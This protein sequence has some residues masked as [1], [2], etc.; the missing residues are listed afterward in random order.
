MPLYI[1]IAL[2][3]LL[4]LKS[5][6]LSFMT[7][8]SFIGITVGVSAL[9][10]T[11]AVM[12]GFQWGLK[13]KILETSPHIVIFKMTGRF[14]EYSSLY[15]YFTDIKDIEAYQPFIYSQALASKGENVKSV[16]IRGVDPDKDKKIMKVNTKLIAGNYDDLKKRNHVLIGKDVAVA[17]DI[18]V[19]D[20]FKIMSPFGRKTPLGYLPKIKKV[21]VAGI[22]DFGMYEYDSTYI[23]MR[24]DEAQNFFDMKDAVTGIQIKLRNPY[25][26][27]TV[28]KQLE[29]YIS[30][31]YIIR[32][33]MDLN[34][35]L[36]QAL[37]LEKLAMFLV[38][39]LI[40]LVASF[41][42]SSLLITKAREKRKDIAIL[43]TI[44]ADS[45]FILK[46]FL[47]QGMLIGIA[48]TVF[49]TII[50][51]SVIYFGDT[52][53]LVKLNPEVYM[54]DYL[55]L[56]TSIFDITAVFLSSLFIC[57]VSSVLPAYFASRDVP[58]E[59]LRYE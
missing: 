45:S 7:V 23:Q 38:I 3:Y 6:A 52:Y 31:P 1:K 57:F 43:K 5:K 54:I 37:Q 19:G 15:D 32:T 44:G 58:A 35:S 12:S 11:L 30:Y 2:K 8:I 20:S 4:S 24:L 55:P 27:D 34:K 18:W 21:Y 28:K 25:R 14:T 39:A 50:G 33:W 10:I 46:T 22:V 56:K 17:L 53:H 9:L 47:W 49:G 51:L 59:V 26:A 48:G 40:V 16:N 36:F 41:N 29:R 13:E 42:V